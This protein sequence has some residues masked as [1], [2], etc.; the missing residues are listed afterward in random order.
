MKQSITP[1]YCFVVSPDK[2]GR[3]PLV[4]AFIVAQ[5]KPFKSVLRIASRRRKDMTR[6]HTCCASNSRGLK[7]L[8]ES[9]AVMRHQRFC[10]RGKNQRNKTID[11]GKKRNNWNDCAIILKISFLT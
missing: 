2:G 11:K 10:S 5:P 4:G 9:V 7:G 3:P 6:K 1:E 8:R